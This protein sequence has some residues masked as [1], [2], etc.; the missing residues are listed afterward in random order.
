MRGGAI[1][2][3][4]GFSNSDPCFSVGAEPEIRRHDTDD[5]VS[6]AAHA[7][8]SPDHIRVVAEQPGPGAVTDNR[9]RSCARLFVIS[10]EGA[11]EERIYMEYSEEVSADATTLDE[12]R[13]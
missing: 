4:F 5:C 6:F 1:R 8:Q 11:T 2:P 12:L 13:C 9:N 7:H 3:V 10:S